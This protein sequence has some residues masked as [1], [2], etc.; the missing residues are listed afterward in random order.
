MGGLAGGFFDLIHGSGPEQVAPSGIFEGA[1]EVGGEFNTF[2]MDVLQGNLGDSDRFNRM[3]ENIRDKLSG[4]T[5]TQ[6]GRASSFAQNRGFFDSGALADMFGDIDRGETEQFT[7]SIT[8]LLFGLES[9][10]LRSVLPFLGAASNEFLGL[11]NLNTGNILAERQQ[12]LNKGTEIGNMITSSFSPGGGGGG[13]FACWVAISVY[14]ATD[15]RWLLARHYMLNDAPKP[16]LRLYQTH[17]RRVAGWLDRH[18][19]AK[20]FVKPVFD[21]MVKKVVTSN[22]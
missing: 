1:D 10:G 21:W 5:R 20:R 14:G 15:P 6:R 8:E 16:L 3:S 17:G 4:V 7:Q 12:N 13:G 18:A 9:E 19:W 2:L 22:G 11:A